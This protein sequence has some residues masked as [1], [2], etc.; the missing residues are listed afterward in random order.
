M[1]ADGLM[2]CAF[3]SHSVPCSIFALENPSRLLF[4]IEVGGCL[5]TNANRRNREQFSLS[6]V[7]KRDARCCLC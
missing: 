2:E 3:Y 1:P 4:G 7:R 6:A 5:Q